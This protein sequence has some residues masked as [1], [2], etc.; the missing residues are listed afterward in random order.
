MTSYLVRGLHAAQDLST[1]MLFGKDAG[2]K[3]TN[4]YDIVERDMK[5]E[6]V[7]MSKYKGSV[8]CVV[9]VASE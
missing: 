7:H 8:L 6:D 5:G 4:F 3:V 2:S 1:R 9:N